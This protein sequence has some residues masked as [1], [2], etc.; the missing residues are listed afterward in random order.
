M[1]LSD[2]HS[3]PKIL[4]NDNI[5][6]P[7]CLMRRISVVPSS[8]SEITS[9]RR[10]SRALPPALRITWASPREMPYAEAGSIRASMQVTADE[11]G[12]LGRPICVENT[13]GNQPTD[14]IFLCRRQK[15]ITIFELRSILFVCIDEVFLNRSRHFLRDNSDCLRS[16]A[17]LGP[18]SSIWSPR[19]GG[20]PCF[21][22][23]GKTTHAA[24]R[25]QLGHYLES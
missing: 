17:R 23:F 18:P 21:S 24:F 6:Q 16:K 15:Q 13:R 7:V 10:A 1:S 22:W 5:P 19:H 4:T 14:G 3:L 11:A 2:I 12:E 9:D 20:M 8:C 25:A